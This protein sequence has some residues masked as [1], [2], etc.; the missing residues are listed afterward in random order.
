MILKHLYI[1]R[2]FSTP[3]KMGTNASRS[4]EKQKTKLDDVFHICCT[5]D[6][7]EFGGK[8]FSLI[9]KERKGLLA[10]KKSGRMSVGTWGSEQSNQLVERDYF[11]YCCACE[12]GH[13][14]TT[15]R[16]D[17]S[18]GYTSRLEMMNRNGEGRRT[19]QVPQDPV[20]NTG[21]STGS[22]QVDWTD[23]ELRQLSRAVEA[24][25]R[26]LGIK[27]PGFAKMQATYAQTLHMPFPPG[28]RHVHMPEPIVAITLLS[29]FSPPFRA[30]ASHLP[31]QHAPQTTTR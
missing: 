3:L 8:K 16:A 2:F 29:A 6:K 25:A 18:S 17:R 15:I 13:L 27:A 12:P 31:C 11:E 21:R 1:D 7:S 30:R 24:A 19:V 20:D 5:E 9:S 26:K 4:C 14:D 28:V 22:E 10:S 23:E